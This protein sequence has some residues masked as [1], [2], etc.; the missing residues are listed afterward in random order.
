MISSTVVYR[1]DGGLFVRRT[2]REQIW[3]EM[4][5]DWLVRSPSA[6]RDYPDLCT[7]A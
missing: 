3:P 4:V 2:S 1:F 5:R 7:E 6:R